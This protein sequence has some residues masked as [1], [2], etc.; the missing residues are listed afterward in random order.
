M[1]WRERSQ[2]QNVTYCFDSL[3]MI[4]SKRQKCMDGKQQWYHYKVIVWGSF[5]GCRTVLY[6]L[7]KKFFY[8][9]FFK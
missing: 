7:F 2:S 6:S 5:E 1:M 3:Y 4:F 9:Y 8:Y